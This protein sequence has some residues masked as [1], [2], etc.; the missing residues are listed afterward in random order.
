MEAK[1]PKEIE[2][3]IA[4]IKSKVTEFLANEHINCGITHLAAIQSS[5]DH[6][7]NIG[8]SILCTKWGVGYPGGSFVQAIVNNQLMESYGRADSINRQCIEFYCKML[9]NISYIE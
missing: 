2:A 4:R 5:H 7:V 3:Q 8:T 9:Y 6:I 1:D